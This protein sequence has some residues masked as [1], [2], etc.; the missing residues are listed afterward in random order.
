M[1][2]VFGKLKPPLPTDNKAVTLFLNLQ[3]HDNSEVTET[4]PLSFSSSQQSIIT[5][6]SSHSPNYADH[7][8]LVAS[9]HA[10]SSSL[11]CCF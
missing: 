9:S 11:L 4:K 8:R 2:D 3:F 7:C 1:T 6:S 5:V 10:T